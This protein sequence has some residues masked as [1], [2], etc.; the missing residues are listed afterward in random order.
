MLCPLRTVDENGRFVIEEREITRDVAAPVEMSATDLIIDKEAKPTKK[1]IW[2]R[3]LLDL[4]LR[5]NLLNLRLTRQSNL[6]RR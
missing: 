6:C 2:E 1:D 3:K 5:N 4:S